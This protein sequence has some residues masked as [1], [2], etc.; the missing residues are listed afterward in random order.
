MHRVLSLLLCLCACAAPPRA[1]ST[2]GG[3]AS[4]V[5]DPTPPHLL[6]GREVP[7]VSAVREDADGRVLILGLWADGRLVWSE[8]RVFGGPPYHETH[9][10]PKRTSDA[11]HVFGRLFDRWE[12]DLL[13]Y[14]PP[15][16]SRVELIYGAG[17]KDRRLASWHEAF[18]RNPEMVV[19]E[20]GV[21]PLGKRSR[22][23]VLAGCSR[24]YRRFRV[25]WKD[26]RRM[27]EGLVP[28]KGPR[29][30]LAEPAL[31]APR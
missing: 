29:V 19:T 21:E 25:L 7:L 24:E 22:A 23:E 30:T 28:R 11:L 27:M 15:G 14:H 13:A 2:T 6:V 20:R 10:G 16:A 17:G 5:V 8:D 31:P 26:V 12:G 4:L 9:L 1:A 18:E 3:S